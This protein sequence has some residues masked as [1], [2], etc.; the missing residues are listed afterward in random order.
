MSRKRILICYVDNGD[1]KNTVAKNIM[2]DKIEKE[3][4]EEGRELLD[5]FNDLK[6]FKLTFKDSSTVQSAPFSHLSKSIL[7]MGEKFAFTHVYIDDAVKD[8]FEGTPLMNKVIESL[9]SNNDA[10]FDT[11]GK[12]VNFYSLKDSNLEIN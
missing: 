8:V 10:R 7:T 5:K 9:L 12:R 11:S 2:L 6:S 4:K 3:M 1:I